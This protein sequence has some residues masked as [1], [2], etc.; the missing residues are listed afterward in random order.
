M[1][2]THSRYKRLLKNRRFWLAI[3]FLALVVFYGLSPSKLL[4]DRA[5]L[6]GY[7]RS[8]GGWS[9]VFFIQLYALSTIVGAPTVVFTIA[10]GA[11]FG[12]VWGTVYSV[13][14]GTLG[15]IGAFW[16][17]RYFLRSWVTRRLGKHPTLQ[18]FERSVTHYALSFVL[19]V[20]LPP[21]TPFSVENFLFGLTSIPW[22][23]YIMG[24]FL[25]IIPGTIAYTW[26]GVTGAESLAG[27]GFASLLVA[28]G[29]FMVLS[30]LPLI[31][32]RKRLKT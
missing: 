16:V 15:A 27:K 2:P 25:G 13:I 9:P 26:L 22:Q 28:I 7:L 3:A 5:A 19:L 32:A 8:L 11:I 17:S 30:I 31:A 18:K 10:G 21:I 29:F 14:G 24:T 4:M 12:L 20:R 6:M 23:P 1:A